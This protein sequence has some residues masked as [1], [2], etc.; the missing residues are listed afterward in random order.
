M[1]CYVT[2]NGARGSEEI[3][4]EGRLEFNNGGF[5]LNYTIAQDNCAIV[6]RG[7]TLTQSRRGD[8]NTDITFS[9][10]KP[11]VC[12]LYSGELT[13]SVPVKTTQMRVVTE[14]RGVKIYLSYF[15]G[16]ASIVLNLTAQAK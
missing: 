16:G 15:L 8:V 9:N 2:I 7:G 11:T 13:G 6:C 1:D 14:E 10:G 3:H 12:M 5:T 4:T